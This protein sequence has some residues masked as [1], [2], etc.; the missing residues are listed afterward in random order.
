MDR[1]T[2]VAATGTLGLSGCAVGPLRNDEPVQLGVI[3]F[4]NHTDSGQSLDIEVLADGTVAAELTVM[5]PAAPED[6][7]TS[8]LVERQWPTEAARYTIRIYSD[9]EADPVTI[10][11]TES[12]ADSC[13]M[14][15]IN[16]RADDIVPYRAGDGQCRREEY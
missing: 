12:H 15:L 5:L 3:E 7:W 10:T 1:R 13:E 9:I 11:V 2:F 4:Q 14:F 8:R 16:I 6:E